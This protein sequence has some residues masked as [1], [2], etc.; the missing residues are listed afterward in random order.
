[1]PSPAGRLHRIRYIRL[2]KSSP[3]CR[4]TITSGSADGQR[5]SPRLTN[6]LV[7]AAWV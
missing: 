6:L 7:V 2:K 1:M 4:A 3:D 5:R